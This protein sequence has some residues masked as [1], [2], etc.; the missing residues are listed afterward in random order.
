M[1][2]VSLQEI[3]DLKEDRSKSSAVNIYK[4]TLKGPTK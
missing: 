1:T 2:N 4:P 3:K